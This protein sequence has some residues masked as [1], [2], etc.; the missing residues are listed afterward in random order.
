MIMTLN[1][2]KQR[3]FGKER[4]SLAAAAER[5]T[6]NAVDREA[7]L[8]VEGSAPESEGARD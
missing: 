7:R 3:K 1:D 2:T 4:K 6:E 8:A 5:Y